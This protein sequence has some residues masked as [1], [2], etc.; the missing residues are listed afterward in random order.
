MLMALA[1][2][3]LGRIWNNCISTPGDNKDLIILD[4]LNV[5][6]YK[7]I[8]LSVIFSRLGITTWNITVF[9]SLG[10]NHSSQELNA[11]SSISLIIFSIN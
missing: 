1:H 8:V 10:G 9:H 3:I 2:H 6:R 7:H 4:A 11:L 5:V